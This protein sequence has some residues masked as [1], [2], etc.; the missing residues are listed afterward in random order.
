MEGGRCLVAINFNMDFSN[1]NPVDIRNLRLNIEK[2]NKKN[3]ESQKRQAARSSAP[4]PENITKSSATVDK[5]MVAGAKRSGEI[6]QPSKGFIKSFQRSENKQKQLAKSQKKGSLKG[7]IKQGMESMSEITTGAVK[8][9]TSQLLKQSWRYLIPSLGLTLIYI[10]IHVI[11]EYVFGE[12]M[13]CKLGQEWLPKKMKQAGEQMAEK[14]TKGLG[15]AEFMA[16]IFLDLL[17]FALFLLVLT[18]IGLVVYSLTEPTKFI[19]AAWSDVV[20]F[21][22]SLAGL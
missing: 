2:E 11:L 22:R 6:N 13:F 14:F 10:N 7:Q 21:L 8:Q 3:F 15:L 17:A 5:A 12:K 20:N 18:A 16:L 4:L 9:G 19:V 1:N